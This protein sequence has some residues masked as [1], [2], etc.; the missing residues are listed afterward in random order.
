MWG[1]YGREGCRDGGREGTAASSERNGAGAAKEGN[2]AMGKWHGEDQHACFPCYNTTSPP[3]PLAAFVAATAS[4]S[5]PPPPIHLRISVA[6][7]APKAFFGHGFFDARAPQ[8]GS[9]N[10]SGTAYSEEWAREA[11][12]HGQ[13]YRPTWRSWSLGSWR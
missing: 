1:W 3:S 6:L 10:Y 5:T 12:V 11:A 4:S 8:R 9:M 13:P 7:L 2:A